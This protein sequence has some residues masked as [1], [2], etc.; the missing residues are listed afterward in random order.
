MPGDLSPPA[1]LAA[2]DARARG[3]GHLGGRARGEPQ[4]QSLAFVHTL[5]AAYRTRT[6]RPLD[7][8]R[9]LDFGCGWGRL[10]RLLAHD[11][12]VTQLTGVDPWPDALAL[13]QAHGVRAEVAQSA[14]GPSRL[15]VEG[16]FDLIYAF[17]VFTHLA[18]PVALQAFQALHAVLAPTGLLVVTI[19]PREY[20]QIHDGG[21]AAA[22]MGA[23]HDT[24]GAAFLPAPWY[25]QGTP[26][27]PYGD[28]S[29]S[30]AWLRQLPGWSLAR[31]DLN[32]CDPYQL[33]VVL[34]PQL[35]SPRP[36]GPPG[37]PSASPPAA[38]I[39]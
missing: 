39:P 14:E 30:L 9:V 35:G 8:A 23:Q 28:T 25:P 26:D 3:P 15:P 10:L 20:W 38:S 4:G 22:P 21:R 11:V 17:S 27:V 7:Q 18:P 32:T 29:L 16:L 12:P 31:L 36:P 24:H 33:I 5:R 1:G 2:H 34:T 19:R 6:P 13:C 37:A